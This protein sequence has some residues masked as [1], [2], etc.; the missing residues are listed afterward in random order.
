MLRFVKCLIDPSTGEVMHVREAGTPDDLDLMTPESVN[1]SD[2]MEKYLSFDTEADDISPDCPRATDLIRALECPGAKQLRFKQDIPDQT[3]RAKVARITQ[4][5]DYTEAV[6][7]LEAARAAV[8]QERLDRI[9][10]IRAERQRA[11]T[12]SEGSRNQPQPV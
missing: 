3:V 12:A 6:Q 1:R 4:T 5:Y 2:L 10:A 8:E 9:T 7:A 11:I